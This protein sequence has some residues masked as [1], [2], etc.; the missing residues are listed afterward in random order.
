MSE[1][2]STKV[3]DNANNNKTV[4]GLKEEDVIFII[5]NKRFELN[6]KLIANF[7]KS[8][9]YTLLKSEMTK[10]VAT[11]SNGK[12]VFEFDNRN[13]EIFE[14]YIL[15]YLNGIPLTLIAD[16]QTQELLN[17]EL[18][19]FGLLSPFHF[20]LSNLESTGTGTDVDLEDSEKRKRNLNEFYFI[21]QTL[22]NDLQS[23]F[24]ELQNTLQ[25]TKIMNELP[26][27]LKSFEK[28]KR[29]NKKGNDKPLKRKDN[30]S[31]NEGEEDDNEEDIQTVFR[32]E[33]EFSKMRYFVIP[34]KVDNQEENESYQNIKVYD[35]L[36]NCFGKEVVSIQEIE[37]RIGQQYLDYY[38]TS[39]T[40]V[41]IVSNKKENNNN[42]KV[43]KKKKKKDEEEKMDF[44]SLLDI[45]CEKAE[46]EFEENEGEKKAT[47]IVSTILKEYT[48]CELLAKDCIENGERLWLEKEPNCVECF[49]LKGI[50]IDLLK[51]DS[52]TV[53]KLNNISSEPNLK[54]RKR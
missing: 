40:P 27:R 15:P 1:S 53:N 10:D 9:L 11:E 31:D 21:S 43:Q 16:K 32:N 42:E 50:V 18:L 14:K 30:G 17:D 39:N 2:Q 34:L 46:E 12:R 13:S 5:N 38:L 49:K 26:K 24:V 20:E 4:V 6:S 37:A 19:Y 54:K 22:Q 7:P 28:A 45:L 48:F 25:F 33:V 41:I 52:E 35:S 44:E 29:N 8:M 3:N 47:E 23:K 51:F 36:V